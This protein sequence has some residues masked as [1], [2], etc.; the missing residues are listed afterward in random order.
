VM[1]I[2]IEYWGGLSEYKWKLLSVDDEKLCVLRLQEK[3]N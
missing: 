1:Q 3:W 2:S